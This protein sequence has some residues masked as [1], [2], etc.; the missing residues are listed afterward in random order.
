MLNLFC[1]YDEREQIGFHVFTSSVIRRSTVPVALT[2]ISNLSFKCGSNKFTVSRFAI[3]ALMNFT[4]RAIFMDGSDMLMVSDI[5]LY[6]KTLDDMTDAVAVVKH[7]YETKH[8]RKY[9]GTDMECR[10][11]DYER[12]NWAS[13]MMI[14][15]EHPSWRQMTME[16]IAEEKVIDLLQLKFLKDEEIAELDQSYNLLIDEDQ[17]VGGAKLLHW[18]AGIPW[19]ESYRTARGSEHWW[20]EYKNAIYN[21][22]I[23]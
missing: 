21:K 20:R 16:R 5:A 19:F 11:E 2:P 10:N 6:K 22:S 8:S 23:S 18:T 3:P 14:N 7:Q 1:G 15:C 9:I 4:G 12:K 13:M 17:D